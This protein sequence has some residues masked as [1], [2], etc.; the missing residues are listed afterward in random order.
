M[1]HEEIVLYT[2]MSGDS[3]WP[4][5]S[6]SS[7]V[8]RLLYLT[9]GFVVG[10]GIILVILLLFD[11]ISFIRDFGFPP[12]RIS[13]EMIGGLLFAL[14]LGMIGLLIVGVS[15]KESKQRVAGTPYRD[16]AD[17][18]KWPLV[19][20]IGL[21]FWGILIGTLVWIWG[22]QSVSI[23]GGWPLLSLVFWVGFS[24]YLSVAKKVGIDKWSE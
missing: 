19:V 18:R 7:R 16:W 20:G 9:E 5:P 24:L 10:G 2:D 4:L 17:I 11:A 23:G 12:R 14:V 8:R 6:Q 15:W 1:C 21:S 3:N 22:W 13:T